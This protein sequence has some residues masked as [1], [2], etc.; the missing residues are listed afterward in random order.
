MGIAPEDNEG[1]DILYVEEDPTRFPALPVQFSFDPS[2][3]DAPYYVEGY[4]DQ[5]Y[6]TRTSAIAA[7]RR[8]Y[9]SSS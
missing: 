7:A 1:Q 2:H 4:P 6:R 8:L 3:L 9:G 5:Y